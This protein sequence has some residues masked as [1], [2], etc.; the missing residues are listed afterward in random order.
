MERLATRAVST[1]RRAPRLGLRWVVAPTAGRFGL[2]EG[3]RDSG[4]VS[5]NSRNNGACA[6]PSSESVR[7]PMPLLEQ[8]D[9]MRGYMRTLRADMNRAYRDEGAHYRKRR[10]CPFVESLRYRRITNAFELED[11][12][13]ECL[14]Q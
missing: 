2:S 1:S 4:S 6:A 3:D 11:V 9:V 10:V 8:I 5:G 14:N 7:T 13:E 12:A